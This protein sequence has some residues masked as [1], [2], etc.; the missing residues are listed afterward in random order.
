[1]SSIDRFRR[2]QEKDDDS[3]NRG[4]KRHRGAVA[5]RSRNGDLAGSWPGPC[6][7]L[8]YQGISRESS[9]R[10]RDVMWDWVSWHTASLSQWEAEGAE[11]GSVLIPLSRPTSSSSSLTYWVDVPARGGG[12]SGD[13]GGSRGAGH[14]APAAPASE[15]NNDYES[16]H[17]VP[18]F[19]RAAGPVLGSDK[20]ALLSG[21]AD[22]ARCFNCGSYAHT[23]S[24]CPRKRDEDAILAAREQFAASKGLSTRGWP[25]RYH[26]PA[27][28]RT[29]AKA[30]IPV[31]HLR[32]GVL[33]PELRRALSIGDL[34][35]PPWLH[36]MQEL[37][38]PPEYREK[39]LD[40]DMEAD[41]VIHGDDSLPAW[42]DTAKG[43]DTRGDSEAQHLAVGNGLPVHGVDTSA[44][45]RFPGVNAPIP[46]YVDRAKW[47]SYREPGE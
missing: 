28:L 26:V 18:N 4:Q 16:C 38:I 7:R 44:A 9:K 40:D 22:D 13:T 15:F 30:S 34:D 36:R 32:P 46:E 11:S 47:E 21:R 41:I 20:D 42:H 37:G 17:D 1:M 23:L 27:T 19:D 8:I 24:D 5:A 2:L 6:L 45:V 3:S 43:P 10:L 25:S 33:S 35:P 31:S 14:Y 12:G 29:G 39:P